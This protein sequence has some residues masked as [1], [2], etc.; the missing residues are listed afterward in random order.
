[1][2]NYADTLNPASFYGVAHHL[3][4]G[5]SPSS[6]DSFIPALQALTNVFPSMPKFQTEY[7]ET[8]MI[9][10]ALL[11]HHS[12]VQEGVSCYIFWSLVWPV[13]G[14]AL[15]EQENPWNLSSWTNAPPGTPT[16]SH[17]YWLTPEYYAVKHFSFFITPGFR[18][19]DTPGDDPNARLSAYLS[20]DNSRLVVVMINPNSTAYAVTNALNGFTVGTSA[21]YQTVGANAQTSQFAPLGTAP[22]NLQW[23]L[24]GY[25]ITTVVLDAPGHAGPA[26]NPNP[27]N[28]A[29]NIAVAPGLSWLAGSNTTSHRVYFGYN[30]NSVAVATTNSPEYR[31]NPPG[32]SYTPATLAS[33]GRYYWRVDELA[34]TN[35]TAGPTWTFA[36]TVNSADAPQA[37]GAFTN[38]NSFLISFAS[39]TGQTYRVERSDSLNPPAWTPVADGVAGTGNLIQI[40]DTSATY[41][42]PRFYRVLLLSP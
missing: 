30:S 13:G 3:Y 15:V 2:Q 22:A 32:A 42:G 8:D 21:V 23:T 37:A 9:Q 27:T 7:G 11:M 26:S 41:V 14:P 29:Y 20:P 35:A 4:S 39:R 19:V 40:A 12:L 34:G 33:T 10:T 38:S 31:G 18:R 16:Q 6:A 24:P 28:G 1:V 5:G 25:S 36:T 17:G